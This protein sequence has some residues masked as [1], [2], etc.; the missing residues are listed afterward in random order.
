MSLK[1]IFEQQMEHKE[2]MEKEVIQ[3]MEYRK[4]CSREEKNLKMR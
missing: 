3:T 1:E 4:R 2:K